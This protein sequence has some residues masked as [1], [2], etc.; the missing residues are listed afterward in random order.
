MRLLRFYLFLTLC[1]FIFALLFGCASQTYD[2][3]WAEAEA[4]G[5]WT[6]VRSYEDRQRRKRDETAY[7]EALEQY[8]L[9]EGQVMFCS[10][11]ARVRYDEDCGCIDKETL[12]G[13]LNW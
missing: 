10:S 3:M 8:C 7:K 9:G 11:S 6:A 12:K 4:T 1:F 2:E 13:G 5:D